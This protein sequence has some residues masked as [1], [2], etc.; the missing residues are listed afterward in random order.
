MRY[1]DLFIIYCAIGASF[2]AARLF[3]RDP[4]RLDAHSFAHAGLIF[5]FYPVVIFCGA[6]RRKNI[7][8]AHDAD[9]GAINLQKPRIESAYREARRALYGVQDRIN[10]VKPGNYEARNMQAS[11]ERYVELTRVAVHINLSSPLLI[12]PHLT[13]LPRLGGHTGDDLDCASRCL[14]RRNKRKLQTH[15]ERARTD[16][17]LCCSALQ[18]TATNIEVDSSGRKSKAEMRLISEA[19]LRFLAHMFTL[20]SLLDDPP[21]AVEINHIVNAECARLRRFA[22]PEVDKLPYTAANSSKARYHGA[23]HRSA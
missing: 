9:I 4:H 20:A 19:L 8:A 7:I 16:L 3:H 15:M 6:M 14:A 11:L 5:A 21:T 23:A 18:C 17:V 13:A 2:A 10:V 12:S 1:Y 22:E